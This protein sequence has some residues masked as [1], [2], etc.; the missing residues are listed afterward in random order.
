MPT[1]A[2]SLFRLSVLGAVAAALGACSQIELARLYYANNGSRVDYEQALPLTLPFRDVDGWI[3][4]PARINGSEPVDFVLDTG[5]SVIALLAGPETAALQLD[6]SSAH[7]FGAEDD[8]AAPFG[9]TQHGLDIDFGPMTLRR[10]TAL[11]IPVDTLKCTAEVPAPPFSGVIGHE[12]F[13]RFV[14]EVDYDRSI[15]TLHDPAGYEYRGSGIVV[16]ADISARQPFVQAVVDPPQGESYEARLHV[17]S[18]AGIDLSLFPATHPEIQVPEGGETHEACF[19]G[20][21]AEY[22]RGTSV[23]LGLGSGAPMSTPASYALGREIIDAGQNG[24]L[25]AKFLRRY[26]VIFDYARERMILEPRRE[27][28][29]DNVVDAG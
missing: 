7:R 10:Q 14:V 4:V 3:L 11:A 22:H 9:A 2:S 18:G 20:G 29:R 19:V 12:I 5:A 16:A 13:H 23:A 26:N 1:P 21:R 28:L 27:G 25:G 17:D 8:L 6:M 24:R 15:V